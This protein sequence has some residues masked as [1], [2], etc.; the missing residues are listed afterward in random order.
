[1]TFDQFITKWLGKR[2]DFDGVYGYQCVDL[3]VQ[4]LAEVHG[5]TSGVWGNAIDYWTKPTPRLLQDFDKLP[6]G[7]TIQ[8]GDIV[9]LLPTST[10]PYGHIMLGIN[11]NTALEQN[12]A[13]GDG[14]GLGGD[15]IRYRTITLSRVAGILRKKGNDDMITKEDVGPV[16]IVMSEVEGWDGYEVHAG[17]RDEEI[18]GAWVGHPWTDMLWH[19]WTV[20]KAHRHD[21]NNQIVDLGNKITDL[22]KVVTIKDNAIADQQ[23]EIETLK[24]QVGDTTK[25]ET[26]KALV[27]ELVGR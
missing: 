27:R 2:V 7:T 9:V 5:I 20:Q 19:C 24:A 11:A 14:D 10:N 8:K 3:I 4:Y 25:W 18:M 17:K 13:T 21:L 6:A 16:R 15:E 1:M 12:G 23:K 26:L 22:G